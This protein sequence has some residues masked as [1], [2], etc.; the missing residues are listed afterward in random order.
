MV[1]KKHLQQ[2]LEIVEKG[3]FTKAASA[4]YMTQAALS[5]S[6]K[7]LE[8]KLGCVL[9]ART[10]RNVV[11]TPYGEILLAAARQVLP[12]I[13]AAQIELEILKSSELGRIAVGCIPC[14][15]EVL[16]APAISAML[17]S[18]PNLQCTINTN[19]W[20]TLEDD[21]VNRRIHL[22]VGAPL[23]NPH[24]SIKHIEIPLSR[25]LYF[26]RPGHPIF[27]LE[28]TTL[29]EAQGYPFIKLKSQTFQA[30]SGGFESTSESSPPFF[31]V[32]CNDFG[33][34]KRIVETTDSV[35]SCLEMMLSEDLRSGRFME[36][37]PALAGSYLWAAA[38]IA[39]W[40]DPPLGRMV[41]N[42]IG[43]LLN[44]AGNWPSK[45]DDHSD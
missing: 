16:L 41:Q 25:I 24:P 15:S 31:S 43:E 19:S 8:D 17:K 37:P 34:V 20:E 4:L 23:V 11:P 7:A 45:T 3:S 21:L 44:V 22:H 6:I 13:S 33:T 32:E 36:I 26:I 12:V 1:E 18:N 2:L 10:P 42:L 40:D 39:Y 5:K 38:Y 27:E 28:N 14:F 35:G 9:L 29:N 30:F